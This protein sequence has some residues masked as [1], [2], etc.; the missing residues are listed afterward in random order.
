MKTKVIVE[1]NG[2][3]HKMVHSRVKDVCHACSLNKLCAN[4]I[5]SPCLNRDDH[6]VLES[7]N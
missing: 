7:K 2:V 4:K 3:R 5:G 6:F 1:I